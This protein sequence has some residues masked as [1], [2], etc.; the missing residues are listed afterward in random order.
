[1][2]PPP[3][4]QNLAEM[5]ADLHREWRRIPQCQIQRLVQGMRKRLRAV[6]NVSGEHTRY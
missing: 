2:N 4:A 1:M 6:I 3:P 5:E